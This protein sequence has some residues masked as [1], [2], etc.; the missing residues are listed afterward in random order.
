MKEIYSWVPWFKEL[1]SKIAE[2][3]KDYLIERAQRVAWKDGA[4]I[5]PLLKFG[6]ENIDPLSFIYTVASSNGNIGRRRVYPS[7][8]EVFE[9]SSQLDPECEHSFFFPAPPSINT[10][11]HADGIGN[12]NL[13]WG[14]FRNAC[15]G[16]DSV[17]PDDF[18]NALQL[19]NVGVRNLTQ[20]LYLVNPDEFLPIDSATMS[21]ESFSNIPK[22]MGL[23]EYKK[24]IDKIMSYFPAC[25]PY[26]ANLFAYLIKSGELK[27]NTTNVFQVG[28]K[29]YGPDDDDFWD[30]FVSENAVFVGGPA[31]KME[32]PIH[33]PN[34]GDLILVRTGRS[35]GRGIG[36]VYENEF[37]KNDFEGGFN[38]NHRL[39]VLW[40]N[41]SYGELKGKAPQ[42]GF[43]RAH[44]TDNL[45]RNTAEYVPTFELLGR[46]NSEY[47]T[48]S[49]NS[50]PKQT[51]EVAYSVNQIIYGPPGTGKTYKINGLKNDYSSIEQTINHEAWL[52][53]QLQDVTWFD[54]VFAALY[55][56]GGEVKVP[57][58][59]KH[60]YVQTKAKVSGSDR[61]LPQRIWAVLQRHTCE[62]STTIQFKNRSTPLVFD[63]IPG[64]LWLLVDDWKEEC[65]EQIELAEKWKIGPISNASHD[66][67]E[68]VTFHQSYSYEDF[69]EGIRPIK[70]EEDEEIMYEVVPGVFKRICQRAKA[71]PGQ[72]YAIFIDE[73]NRGNIAKIFGEL[74]T[75]IEEDKRAE[76]NNIGDLISGMELTLPYSG[77]KFSVPK[78]LDI[79]GTMNTADRSISLIDTALRRRFQF[80]ELMPDP[81]VIQGSNGNGKIKCDDGTEIDLRALLKVMNLRIKFL[82]KRDM[83]L[84]HAYLMGV[85]NFDG[86]KKALFDKIIP[87]LQ[88]Y[89][90]EDWHKIQLVFG[91]VG[92]GGEKREP[93]IV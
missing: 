30:K 28:T 79:Y 21:L 29:A 53:Q 11:F 91:D 37:E 31:E 40:L 16:L 20:V 86:L 42:S 8:S 72:R 56:M 34:R 57:A 59:V 19:R 33:E 74:I 66:R 78:N 76:Y 43:S 60:E 63:K 82:L 3:G 50:Q 5:P 77:S 26:E 62:N 64:S 27:V 2:G 24:L 71:D 22:E 25:R 83:M 73:I 38:P 75:L 23:E 81:D 36:I 67:Y 41:K 7:V 88:E 39:H 68:Y 87:L 44:D 45:Y 14:L 4:G 70:T 92:A 54:V 51:E 61:N 58:L 93:Q 15:E 10:L 52:I 6:D 35:M 1:G 69:V 17:S 85:E 12:P 13:L 48:G 46:L 49:N 47:S 65:L 18:E 9:I 32:Y 55:D 89:F 84:G 90:Y 80:E